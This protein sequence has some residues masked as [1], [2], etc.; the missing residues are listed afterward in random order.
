MFVGLISCMYYSLVHNCVMTSFK[1][2]IHSLGSFTRDPLDTRLYW[3]FSNIAGTDIAGT[4]IF[5]NSII[6]LLCMYCL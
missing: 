3:F 4:N 6:L 5:V 1:E 2:C